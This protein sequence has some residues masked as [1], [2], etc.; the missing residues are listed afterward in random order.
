MTASPDTHA[1][2][3]RSMQIVYRRMEIIAAADMS[4][5]VKIAILTILGNIIKD[6]HNA[7]PVLPLPQM[8]ETVRGAP[9]NGAGG[10]IGS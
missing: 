4:D 6:I 1:E 3:L 7:S 10:N 9:D 2:R 5:S 8:P